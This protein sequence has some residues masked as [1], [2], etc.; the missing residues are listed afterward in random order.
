MTT[1]DFEYVDEKLLVLPKQREMIAYREK[2]GASRGGQRAG[3]T[4]AWVYWLLFERMEPYPEANAVVVGATYQQLR[5]G[6]FGTLVDT[7]WKH[8]FEDE[9]D[10]WYRRSPRPWLRRATAR[11]CTRGPLRSWRAYDRRTY[12]RS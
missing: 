1:D 10:F 2:W 4:T 8:G 11:S 6:I 7:L 12:R 3:K 5:D 9:K